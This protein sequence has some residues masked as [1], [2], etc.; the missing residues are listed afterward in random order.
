MAFLLIMIVP[1]A[2]LSSDS[3]NPSGDW[4]I[5]QS[6]IRGCTTWPNWM[7]ATP[8]RKNGNL[9]RVEQKIIGR[10]S[11]KLGW[12]LFI[13]IIYYTL[14]AAPIEYELNRDQEKLYINP[15]W[16]QILEGRVSVHVCTR[17]HA[18]T[19]THTQDIQKGDLRGDHM[20]G[21]VWISSQSDH[22]NLV[23]CEGEI[24]KHQPV[25]T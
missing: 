9:I 1:S 17:T 24:W 4:S 25:I 7:H 15:G 11:V 21:A 14:P 6:R 19:C 10:M 3:I 20:D 8:C 22:P 18:H 13:I 5:R 2:K 16:P 12:V 23:I